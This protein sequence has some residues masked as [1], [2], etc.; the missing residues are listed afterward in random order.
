[1]CVCVSG[2]LLGGFIAF[3]LRQPWYRVKTIGIETGIQ[4]PGVPIFLLKF[5]LPQVCQ[6]AILYLWQFSCVQTRFVS[7]AW[8]R[9]GRCG[10]SDGH[11]IH[12]IAAVA[13][14]YCPTD[15][16]E[17]LSEVARADR[18]GHGLSRHSTENEVWNRRSWSVSELGWTAG[19]IWSSDWSMISLAK[20]NWI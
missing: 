2:F 15:K 6:S 8:R 16:T 20:V 17:V 12:T 13:L 4:N 14:D 3:V 7:I 19:V 18:S 9:F 10:S 1:M 11:H 5:S